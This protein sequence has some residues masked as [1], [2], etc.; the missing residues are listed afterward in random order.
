MTSSQPASPEARAAIVAL[1]FA[2]TVLKRPRSIYRPG[3]QSAW[4][5]HKVRCTTEGVLLSVRQD[6][7]GQWQAI[8]DVAGRWVR[9]LGGARSRA[10]RRPPL[11]STREYTRLTGCDELATAG[12]KVLSKGAPVT[13]GG[14]SHNQHPRSSHA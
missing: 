7:A 4:G 12:Q 3:R 9:A 14:V 1:G 6:H 10:S 13:S 11:A 5:K 2:G 8:C